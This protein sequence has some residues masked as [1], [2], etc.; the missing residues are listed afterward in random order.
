LFFWIFRARLRSKTKDLSDE[1]RKV[2][3]SH[4]W[5]KFFAGKETDLPTVQGREWVKRIP[6][7]GERQ[8]MA[9][10]R[11]E[12]FDGWFYGFMTVSLP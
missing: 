7:K 2:G 3:A 10:N 11:N 6:L 4:R 9:K 1:L 12:P 8:L 5:P